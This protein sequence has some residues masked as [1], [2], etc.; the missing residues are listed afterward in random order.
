MTLLSE[1][2]N[3]L[4]FGLPNPVPSGESVSFTFDINIPTT[5][6]FVI[7][8]TQEGVPIPEPVSV[9]L[10]TF[11]FGALFCLRRIF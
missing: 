6:N 5:G 11:G 7:D 4:T 2:A 10:L 3:L 9:L 8:L 1:T